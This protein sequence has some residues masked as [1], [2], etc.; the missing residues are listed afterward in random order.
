MKSN[1]TINITIFFL[2]FSIFQTISAQ[3]ER[4]DSLANEVYR[5]SRYKKTKSIEML[6]SLYNM[7][8]ISPDS[9]LLIARCLYEE[10]LLHLQQGINDTSLNNR[11][12]DRLKKESLSLQENAFLQSALGTSYVIEGNFTDAFATFLQALEKHKQTGNNRFIAR[13]LNSLGN[14]CKGIGLNDLSEYYFSEA[15]KL[16]TPD[17]DE[18]YVIKVNIISNLYNNEFKID[19]M[20]SFIEELEKGGREEFLPMLYLNI[21]SD[22]LD[23]N[24]EKALLYL[25][26]VKSLDFDD[27]QIK[28][29]V[30]INIGSYFIQI[31]DFSKALDYFK[32]GKNLLTNS[33]KQRDLPGLYKAISHIYEQQ[34]KYDSAYFYLQ[35]C[36]EITKQLR[37]NTKAIETHQKYITTILE[38]TKKDLL[39]SEQENELKQRQ[40]VIVTII[41]V[42]VIFLILLFLI[43]VQQQKHHKISKLNA[44]IKIKEVEKTKQ[45]ELSNAKSRELTSY[46]ALVSNK[47]L[48]LS[49]IM[50]LNSQEYNKEVKTKISEIIRN[51]LNIDEEWTN[52]K[53]HF[54]SVHPNF[55][56]KL[57]QMS[58]DLTEE[59][60]KICAY[61][62]MGMTSKQIAQLMN[63]VKGSV[64][65]S[66][67]RLKKKLQLS[68]EESLKS[69]ICSVKY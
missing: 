56:E 37:S 31:N 41:S 69:F 58:S 22:Y 34:G 18:Y 17:Y 60:L 68:E 4:F 13:T 43:I 12:K 67:Q 42:F 19:S 35:K 26:K 48:I 57:K 39:I 21:G 46:S 27:N 1:N 62:K 8:Y 40:F 11:L 64:D 54:D 63:V 44:E 15:I 66:L 50:E 38:S 32:E 49:Q 36:Y 2:F 7:A 20:L 52:F 29:L 45:E 24:P 5:L 6:D 28:S 30:E 59:N 25:E 14:I 65:K 33:Y 55:F 3:N 16:I 53:L 61:I 23:I 9:S 47:N 10:A 51:N